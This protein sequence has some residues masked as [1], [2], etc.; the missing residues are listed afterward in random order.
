MADAT[1]QLKRIVQAWVREAQADSEP[2]SYL[3][4]RLLPRF[5]PWTEPLE[6]RVD[7]QIFNA[8][9]RDIC[10][11]GVGFTCK[12]EIARGTLIEMRPDGADYWVPILVTHSTSTVGGYKIGARFVLE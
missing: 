3:G 4:K 11:G 6:L 5:T 9:G 8:R 1:Q 7:G 12:R 2:D 10:L